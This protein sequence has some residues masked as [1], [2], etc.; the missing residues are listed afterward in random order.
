MRNASVGDDLLPAEPGAC[1]AGT[2]A[3][4]RRSV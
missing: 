4:R 2:Q 3:R 1:V